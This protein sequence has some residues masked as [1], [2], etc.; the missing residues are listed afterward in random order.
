MFYICPCNYEQNLIHKKNSLCFHWLLSN[1]EK[2]MIRLNISFVVT[3]ILVISFLSCWIARTTNIWIEMTSI[4]R[5]HFIWL[6]SMLHILRNGS[7]SGLPSWFPKQLKMT[8]LT[9]ST[10]FTVRVC[11]VFWMSL[12]IFYTSGAED[13]LFFVWLYSL[14][15]FHLQRRAVT[16]ANHVFIVNQT[17]AWHGFSKTPLTAS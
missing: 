3:V 7:M 14:S 12:Q 10:V 1:N 13:V 2:I 17:I 16:Q 8:L 15:F 11:Q 6:E 9:A 5:E 4:S